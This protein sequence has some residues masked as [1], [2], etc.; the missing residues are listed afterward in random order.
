MVMVDV[1][2]T[3]EENIISDG[4]KKEMNDLEYRKNQLERLQEKVVDLEDISNGISITDLT[5]NDFKMS[6]MN[7]ME[8]NREK[9]EKSPNGIYALVPIPE[10]L[11]D[12][13]EPG[14][15]FLLKQLRGKEETKDRN[16]LTPYY[17]VYI[18]E[19]KQVKLN[20][21]QSK[22][23]LD[24][25]QKICTGQ[26]KIYKELVQ[27]FEEETNNGKDMREYSTLLSTAI[28]NILGKKDEI[29]VKSLFSKGGTAT[30]INEA[31][32]LD[33]FELITFLIIK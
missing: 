4:S 30:I 19:D 24:Y 6:L 28:D 21:I 14:V 9:L 8:E 16:A 5:F 15:I 33:E 12:E 31:A 2:A 26:K 27:D 13:I 20:Y 10:E 29:G 11:K 7:Y 17:L 32:G 25:Y 3:G 23:I 18:N 22:K 1:S